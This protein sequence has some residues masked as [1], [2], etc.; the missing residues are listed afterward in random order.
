MR[1]NKLFLEGGA[2]FVFQ[3]GR[4]LELYVE[5]FLTICHHATCDN[6]CLM[7]GFWCVLDEDLH[8]VMP[9][10][11]PC[12][13]LVSYINFALWTSG[14][15]FTVSEAKD[16]RS[17]VQPHPTDVSQADPE[18]SPPAPITMETTTP[19]PPAD[20]ELTPAA[21]M[22]PATTAPTRAPEP[23]FPSLPQLSS[24]TPSSSPVLIVSKVKSL[25]LHSTTSADQVDPVAQPPASDSLVP[26]WTV[27]RLASPCLLPPSTPPE[28]LHHEA[29]PGS[30]VPS[31]RPWS[32]VTLEPRTYEPPAALRLSTP[33]AAVGSSFPPD[34]PRSTVALAPL[35]VSGA[36]MSPRAFVT[37]PPPSASAAASIEV[38]TNAAANVDE[39]V[40]GVSSAETLVSD[41]PCD[42][43][44]VAVESVVAET[45]VELSEAFPVRFPVCSLCDLRL[46]CDLRGV[47]FLYLFFVGFFTC[48]TFALGIPTTICTWR[49]VE[50]P[51]S[52]L[53]AAATVT[54][55]SAICV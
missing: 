45:V 6:V 26:P 20:G 27:D 25:C 22:E 32:V 33:T 4:D 18:H 19:E 13:T 30:H 38:E 21:R 16:S 31:A 46:D 42:D 47:L 7:E 34:S 2:V 28:T 14:S 15:E 12:W 24:C 49:P 23:K 43:E 9:R 8:F 41:P 50:V 51:A 1:G 44:S 35:Q 39:P 55:L 10:G 11:D 36:L 5:E 37:A 40:A 53:P 17:L 48:S 3:S 54:I 29:A 52:S